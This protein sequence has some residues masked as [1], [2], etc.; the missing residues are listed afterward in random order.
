M[1]D[2]V[3]K[4][5]S[6]LAIDNGFLHGFKPFIVIRR[7]TPINRHTFNDNRRAK[8]EDLTGYIKCEHVFDTLPI[9]E[10]ERNMIDQLLI[11]GIII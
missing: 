4:F 9:S 1:N 6:K 5:N 2:A 3:D 10:I 11:D 8:V 7:Y